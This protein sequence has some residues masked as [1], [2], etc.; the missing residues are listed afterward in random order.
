MHKNNLN[1]PKLF[2]KIKHFFI[3]NY[4][5]IFF[6]IIF[7][8]I[9]FLPSLL[10]RPALYQGLISGLSFTIGY[11][12]GV[13]ISYIGRILWHKE[14]SHK[15][16]IYAWWILGTIGTLAALIYLILGKSWQN[17]VR[18]LVGEAPFQNQ[19]I[20][21]IAVIA[22]IVALILLIICRLIFKLIKKIGNLLNR[23]MPKQ[24]SMLIGFVIMGIII[25]LFFNGVIFKLF[26]NVTN[27]IYS[28]VNN[29]TAPGINQPNQPERSGSPESLIPWNTLGY[30]G[31][32]FV[33]RGPSQQQLQNFS[34]QAPAQQIR[35]Y[36]G[37]Q[38]APTPEARAQLVV[39]ELERTGAFNRPVL[40]VACSTG[41]GWLEPQSTDSLEYM[42]SGNSA[43]ASVQYS[44]LPSWIGFLV[45]KQNATDAGKTLYDAVYAKWLTLPE[46]NR[47]KLI[48]YGLS[49]GSFGG[50][51]AFSNVDD[52]IDRTDG[53]LFMGTPS[54]TPLWQNIENNRDKGTPEWQPT[55]MLGKNVRFGS[56]S[57]SFAKPYSVTW[58]N[59]HIV[60]MQHASDSVVWW[61]WD[62]ILEKPDWLRETRGPDVSPSM[63]WFPFVTFAQVTVDQFFGVDV[64]NGHGHNYP[65]SI[66]AA[67]SNVV[68]PPSWTAD[69]AINLQQIINT[70]SNE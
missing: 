32:N 7:F 21:E 56:E 50:Q 51:S 59:P 18:T 60:I 64:P 34:G 2:N 68:P 25:V 13:F 4:I 44:Y 15:I 61:N 62:L 27:N 33:A 39:Q 6:G 30:Q 5:G 57:Y 45:D 20:L 55:Y 10:P 37:L 42:Y 47:P 46:A 24:V 12:I 43:I 11:G 36:A 41:T 65:N 70:Y 22:F 53:A 52:L 8:C 16:K 14:P 31:R 38:S 54:S 63:R 69:Q 35:V 58:D 67:W 3:F 26:T 19:H 1:K 40:V 48:A 49:M 17:Q 28:K 9:S 66:V 29:T 23:W